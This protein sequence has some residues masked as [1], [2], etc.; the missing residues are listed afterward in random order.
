MCSVFAV[1]LSPSL[2]FSRL[3]STFYLFHS[4]ERAHTHFLFFSL[5]LVS[6]ISATYCRDERQTN[7]CKRAVKLEEHNDKNLRREKP[8]HFCRLALLKDLI[9]TLF[10]LYNCSRYFKFKL[11]LYKLLIV[12]K[13]QKNF[14]IVFQEKLKINYLLINCKPYTSFTWTE[15]HVQHRSVNC[16][17][18]KNRHSF[19]K[20]DSRTTPIKKHE[21]W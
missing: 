2:S 21:L 1:S 3:Y 10:N 13:I 18:K 16:I 20:L 6:K 4:F 12:V 11:M 17:R 9:E 14:V 7:N 8:K 5:S 19:I 15:L